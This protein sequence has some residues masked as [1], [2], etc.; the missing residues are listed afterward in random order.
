MGAA[1]EPK[2]A[3][4]QQKSNVITL[5]DGVRLATDFYFP[6]GAGSKLPAILIRPL[7]RQPRPRNSRSN[8]GGVG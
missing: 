7:Y 5:R 1:L 2:Y 4:R 8:F 3:V 6:E